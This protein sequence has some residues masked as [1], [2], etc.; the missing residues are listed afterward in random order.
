MIEMKK[1]FHVG[2]E[3][4]YVKGRIDYNE[5]NGI[6]TP[7][8]EW[9]VLQGVVS[10]IIIHPNG[11]IN[12][13]QIEGEE[14]LV[15]PKLIH[16]SME[17]AIS[18]QKKSAIQFNINYF[19]QQK[20]LAF[21]GVSSVG[22]MPLSPNISPV[23]LFVEGDESAPFLLLD[24]DSHLIIEMSKDNEISCPMVNVES[25]DGIQEMIDKIEEL[26]DEIRKAGDVHISIST[27]VGHGSENTL[28]KMGFVVARRLRDE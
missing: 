22:E 26:T 28:W 4:H 3:V 13:Y 23:S 1:T 16:S 15:V 9:E 5:E 14:R 19:I 21:T 7:S 18:C 24:P 6:V 11:K 12:K 25:S 27:P 2:D 10:N 20:F 8:L 17:D